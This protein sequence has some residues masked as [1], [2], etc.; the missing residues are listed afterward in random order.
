MVDSVILQSCFQ[1]LP[2]KKLFEVRLTRKT[3]VYQQ[4]SNTSC[5]PRKLPLISVNLDDIYGAK[6]FRRNAK[7]DLNAYMH[8][9][10]CP[11]KGNRRVCQRIRFKFGGWDELDANIR[12]AQRWVKTILL[13][14]QDPDV[15]INTINGTEISIKSV[16]YR[17]LVMID[18]FF[19]FD[20]IISYM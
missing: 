11:L 8:I 15:D 18:V 14:S 4:T 13:L 10:A 5:N 7:D 16:L 9:F 12:L 2:G 6:V 3:L 17:V 1:L 19:Y 20:C